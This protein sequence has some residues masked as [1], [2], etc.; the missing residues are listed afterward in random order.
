M[1]CLR[2]LQLEFVSAS[3][4][5]LRFLSP[6]AVFVSRMAPLRVDFSV[7]VKL[8]PLGVNNIPEAVL[9]PK[10]TSMDP[11]ERKKNYMMGRKMNKIQILA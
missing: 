8:K 10:D 1:A 2:V 4:R 5:R 3:R 7:N 6:A 9:L 11:E